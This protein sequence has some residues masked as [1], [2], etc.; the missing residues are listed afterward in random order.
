MRSGAG[1]PTPLAWRWGAGGAETGGKLEGGGGRIIREEQQAGA[2]RRSR[3][4]E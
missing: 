1:E 2:G 4:E 3:E